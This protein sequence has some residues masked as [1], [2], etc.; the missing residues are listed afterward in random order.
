MADCAFGL[1]IILAWLLHEWNVDNFQREHYNEPPGRIPC[2]G[3]VCVHVRAAGENRQNRRETGFQRRRRCNEDSA[4][5]GACVCHGRWPPSPACWGWCLEQPASSSGRSQTR[6]RSRRRTG[7]STLY[8]S[9]CDWLRS[10]TPSRWTVLC[11][12]DRRSTS[13]SC[14]SLHQNTGWEFNLTVFSKLMGAWASHH[15][16]S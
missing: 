1:L 16:R 3:G 2:R 7:G 10:P 11:S 6:A 12:A 14:C 13:T 5:C 4:T 9:W 8:S 15:G